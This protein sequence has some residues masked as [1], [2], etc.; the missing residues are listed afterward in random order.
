MLRPRTARELGST[1]FTVFSWLDEWV[2]T[3]CNPFIHA[4]LYRHRFPRCIQDAYMVLSCHRAKRPS[5]RHLVRRLLVEKSQQL[6]DESEADSAH[7][8]SDP[9]EWLAQVQALLIYQLIG[10]YDGDAKLRLIS[11]RHMTVLVSW[12]CRAVDCASSCWSLGHFLRPDHGDS[13]GISWETQTWHS[14]ILAESLRRTWL[15]MST[16]QSIYMSTRDGAARC[17]GGMMCTSRKGFW[18]ASS[19]KAWQLSCCQTYAGLGRL[20]E[21]QKL[22]AKV[23][24]RDVNEFARLMLEVT[25]GAVQTQTWGLTAELPHVGPS[26]CIFV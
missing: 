1:L 3:G 22:L 17:L 4:E 5:N 10:L 12:M 25:F 7:G 9:L 26:V 21:V 23:P 19:A 20:T 18:E 11:E 13:A 14:W 6:V 24:P 8:G 16:V 15:V 2:E